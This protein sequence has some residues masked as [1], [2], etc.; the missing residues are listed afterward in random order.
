MLHAQTTTY[1]FEALEVV[2][3]IFKMLDELMYTYF[4]IFYNIRLTIPK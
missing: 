2:D 1:F 4:K 3:K